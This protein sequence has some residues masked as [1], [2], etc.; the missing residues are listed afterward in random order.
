LRRFI[1][2]FLIR[3]THTQ[4]VVRSIRRYLLFLLH[5]VVKE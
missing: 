3:E 5:P 1:A 2:Y 4:R